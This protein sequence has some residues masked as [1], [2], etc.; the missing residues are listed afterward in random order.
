M[1]SKSFHYLYTLWKWFCKWKKKSA[2][3]FMSAV[4]TAKHDSGSFAGQKVSMSLNVQVFE[5]QHEVRWSCVSKCV[6]LRE[7]G[8]WEKERVR[9]REKEK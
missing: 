7:R 1:S 9:E 6:C 3:I 4:K 5:R 2:A 8:R